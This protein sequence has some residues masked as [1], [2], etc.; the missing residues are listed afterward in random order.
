[1]TEQRIIEIKQFRKDL[2]EV[3]QKMKEISGFYNTRERSLSVI[4]L[5]EC[6]MWLGMELKELGSQNPYPNSYDTSN[7]K[8]DPVSD[9]LKL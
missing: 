4:K 6:I 9:G 3:L 8:V 1:M 5:Q 2:D 7:A